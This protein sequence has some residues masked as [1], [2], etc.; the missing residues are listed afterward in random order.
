MEIQ[1][2]PLI[3]FMRSLWYFSHMG[4]FR[5]TVAMPPYQ[6]GSILAGVRHS[7]V[8]VGL[9]VEGITSLRLSSRLSWEGRF[10]HSLQHLVVDHESSACLRAIHTAHNALQL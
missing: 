8:A 3:G 7:L 10:L 4:Q 9:V 2:R 6:R 1:S 5:M